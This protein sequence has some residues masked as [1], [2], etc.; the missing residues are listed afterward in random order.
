MVAAPGRFI[1]VVAEK[2]DQI[3]GVADDVA[4]R[5]EITLLVL[6]AG[7][8]GES[9]MPADLA[10]GGRR[11]R[12]ADAALRIACGEPVP[13]PAVCIQPF[14]FY[15]NGMRPLPLCHRFAGAH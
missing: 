5:A 6:L 8:E 13:V 3:R 10:R 7:G 14:D 1:D 9:H 4:I 12:A 11:T 2:G 15:V